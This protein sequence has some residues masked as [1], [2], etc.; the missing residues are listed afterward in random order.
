MSGD[1][2]PVPISVRLESDRLVLCAPKATDITELR[3]LLIRNAE[4]LRPWSPSPPP[5][6]N[7]VGFT[8][9]GRSIARHRRDW[10]AGTGYVFGTLLR[11]LR[12][13]IIGGIAL[14][15]VA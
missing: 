12:Q 1:Q 5:G 14:K 15:S 13:T 3:S 2:A 8:E 7:P 9:L 11:D 6:T 4:H 10:K